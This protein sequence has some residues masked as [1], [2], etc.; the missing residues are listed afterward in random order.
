[1]SPSTLGLLSLGEVGLGQSSEGFL[2]RSSLRVYMTGPPS[3]TEV[4]VSAGHAALS[5]SSYS[6]NPNVAT[7]AGVASI[8]VTSREA[9]T[10]A[11]GA[12]VVVSVTSSN[13]TTT[14]ATVSW[15]VDQP[16]TGRVEYG[17]TTAYGSFTTL[18]TS[19][20]LS[21][22][23]AIGSGV[24][25][26]PLVADTTYHFRVIGENATGQSYASSDQTFTT[27][28]TGTETVGPRAAPAYPTGSNVKHISTSVDDSGNTD[29]T[30][31]LQSFINSAVAG[32]I[33]VFAQSDP[34]GYRHG[35]DTPISIYQINGPLLLDSVPNDV[36]FFGYGTRLRQDKV[37]TGTLANVI[38]L[39]RGTGKDGH[40]FRGFELYGTIEDYAR[41][42]DIYT[43]PGGEK[44]HGISFWRRHTNTLIEDVWTRYN[45]GD[46]IYQA[47]FA[48][49]DYVSGNGTGGIIV[50]YCR[51]EDNRRQGLV[52]NVGAGA[53]AQDG[54]WIH[55]NIFS[56]N[57]GFSID[58]E[59]VK[60]SNFTNPKLSMLI[61][62]NLFDTCGWW[63]GTTGFGAM[64]IN[65][66]WGWNDVVD[67]GPPQFS[68]CGPFIIRRNRVV[69]VLPDS[70]MSEDIGYFY[71]NIGGSFASVTTDGWS[72]YQTKSNMLIE[73]NEFDLPANQQ[74]SA[75][76]AGWAR[77]H[78]GITVQ[79]NTFQGNTVSVPTTGYGSNTSVSVSGNT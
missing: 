37:I 43:S 72:D 9:T 79:N 21:H 41:T 29:V 78:A 33:L 50:R 51:I 74:G 77:T 76:I 1:M 44:N 71:G 5:I 11:G 56:N 53:T 64:H 10:E 75:A 4:T 12:P 49:T 3:Q 22:S 39:Q 59:D 18:A 60:G 65:L 26:T 68:Q 2:T 67:S 30:A 70:L 35:I 40:K 46:G 54:W 8:T 36:E 52:P 19:Y 66:T 42:G 14:T 55:H 28:A 63:E 48:D 27:A 17:T 20:L 73:D 62:D 58:A 32:D 15:T 34:V 69:R 24:N 6:I 25:P 31:A 45:G 61:E 7:L 13:I 57:G 23:Q 16:V 47:G 38:L